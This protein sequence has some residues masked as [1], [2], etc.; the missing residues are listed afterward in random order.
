MLDTDLPD[1]F[2]EPVVTKRFDEDT[3]TWTLS[4]LDGDADELY[5]ITVRHN[6]HADQ[7]DNIRLN[8]N[9][10]SHRYNYE[11]V[12]AYMS[13]TYSAGDRLLFEGLERESSL[14]SRLWKRL[15]R[16]APESKLWELV[17]PGWRVLR[18]QEAEYMNFGK[19]LP[20]D[21]AVFGQGHLLAASGGTRSL[22][23]KCAE[24]HPN[25][26]L[27][28]LGRYTYKGTDENITKLHFSS[29]HEGGIGAGSLIAVE[30]L[31]TD[32]ADVSDV[33]EG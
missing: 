24:Q 3:D 5:R 26:N 27:L 13:A 1:S 30:R 6:D 18:G 11:G 32:L 2:W 19:P 28:T 31:N 23:R 16:F 29:G 20:G 12:E 21:N 33:A 4:G 10:D 15:R 7:R 8:L 25:G 17:A 14:F 22:I 9:G